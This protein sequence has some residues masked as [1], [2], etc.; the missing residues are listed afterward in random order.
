MRTSKPISTISYNSDDFLQAKIEYWKKIGLIEFGMWIRHEPEEDEKKS[1]CHVYLKPAKLI[2]TMDLEED[3][4]ELDPTWKPKDSYKDEKD[5]L[6]H[7]KKM[8]LKMITFRTSKEDDWLLYAIHEPSFLA[9][10]G[11][12]REYTYGIDE[13]LNTCQDTLNDIVSRLSDN[14]KG[15]LEYRLVQCI[16]N[17]MNWQQIVSSGLVPIRQITGAKL[18]YIALTGQEKHID[19]V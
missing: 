13:V 4:R 10:K 16:N 11:L 15:R 7:E 9:E 17:G 1:H 12:T 6:E 18:M 19:Q 14:R 8:F 3:S 5:R 2:Q